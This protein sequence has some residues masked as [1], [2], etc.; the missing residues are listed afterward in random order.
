MNGRKRADKAGQPGVSIRFH[1]IRY[2]AAMLINNFYW[3]D[4]EMSDFAALRLG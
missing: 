3:K 2:G 1:F 4:S